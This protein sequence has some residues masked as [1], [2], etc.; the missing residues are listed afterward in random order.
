MRDY[1]SNLTARSF[2]RTEG[3]PL[4]N[5]RLP[6]LFEPSLE[7]GRE[8]VEVLPELSAN[9][10]PR[11]EPKRLE[12]TLRRNAERSLGG[13]EPAADVLP[14]QD[15]HAVAPLQTS[16]R[17]SDN[18]PLEHF[19]DDAQERPAP[20]KV[21]VA[22]PV[23]PRP[24][25]RGGL[26]PV[27]EKGEGWPTQPQ[28]KSLEGLVVADKVIMKER[29]RRIF[30]RDVFPRAETGEHDKATVPT[31]VQPSLQHFAEDARNPWKDA[32]HR[33]RLTKTEPT[34]QVTIGRI[35]VR[36]MPA[37]ARKHSKLKGP[38]PMSLEEY[39]KGRNGGGR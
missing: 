35:E 36:A 30:D 32:G 31:V 10:Q 6:S 26:F 12:Q 39:L 24:M 5:P 29:V 3:I 33:E 27:H 7:L 22:A 19:P 1:L 25:H 18:K 15:M 9:H 2:D 38:A 4:V 11:E 14:R 16:P 20:K 17:P 37:E 21:T 13:D 34:I 23:Q 8:A 28:G